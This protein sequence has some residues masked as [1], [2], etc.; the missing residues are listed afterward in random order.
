MTEDRVVLT[1][2]AEPLVRYAF[3]EDVPVEQVDVLE[4]HAVLPSGVLP[5]RSR[6]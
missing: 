2:V 4:S 6:L 1:Q 3:G 5:A